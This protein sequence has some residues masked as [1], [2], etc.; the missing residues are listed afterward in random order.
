MNRFRFWWIVLWLMS[1]NL[2]SAQADTTVYALKTKSPSVVNTNARKWPHYLSGGLIALGVWGTVDSSIINKHRISF[3]GKL[4][5]QG[6]HK[7]IDNIGTV[8]PAAMV[9]GLE[10]VGVKPKTDFANRSVI[11]AKAEAMM[12]ISV[13]AIKH[14]SNVERPDG[15]NFQSFPSGHTAQAF[16]SAHFFHKEFGYK[17]IWYSIGGYAVAS[18]VGVMRVAHNRHWITDVM[19]GAGLGILSTEIAYRT[20]RYRWKKNFQFTVLPSYERKI[21]SLTAWVRF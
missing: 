3:Q 19:T 9:Y 1:F 4:E 6:W 18:A 11:L 14:W 8:L 12:L 5:N 20:H 10:W 7:Q 17:S 16:L 15:S 21:T 13:F 2:V